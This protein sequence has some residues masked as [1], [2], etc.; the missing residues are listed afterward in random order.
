[1]KQRL[2][3]LLPVIL[4]LTL[5]A[6]TK[7]SIYNCSCTLYSQGNII[8]TVGT[9]IENTQTKANKQCDDFRKDLLGDDYTSLESA[10]CSLK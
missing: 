1:M 5:S 2:F 9:T 4:L 8:A 6:C 10:N 3:Y 7:K